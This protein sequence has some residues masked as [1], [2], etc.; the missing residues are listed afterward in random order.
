MASRVE[1]D[2]A[3]LD[4]AEQRL[5]ER[6]LVRG[7]A[8]EKREH[9]RDL[10]RR[11]LGTPVQ[12]LG[13]AVLGTVALVVMLSASGGDLSSWP[14]AVATLA[15]AGVF[16]VPAALVA[17]L[18]R[19]SGAAYAIASAMATLGLQLALTFGVAFLLLGLGPE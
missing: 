7:A 12:V 15:M 1:E 10:R 19:S 6:A 8:R 4:R 2:L 5:D 17:A 9:R 13:L 14:G 11:L 16:V 18:A 3:D